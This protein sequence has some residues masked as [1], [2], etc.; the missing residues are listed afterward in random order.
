MCLSPPPGGTQPDTAAAV[1]V[2]GQRA[3]RHRAERDRLAAHSRRYSNGRLG[4]ALGAAGFGGWWL[5]GTPA[6]GALGLASI[7]ALAI[8]VLRHDRV[9][10]AVA[11]AD[12]LARINDEAA[13][14]ATRQWTALPPPVPIEVSPSHPYA[15]DLDLFGH[16][17]V[18]EWLG[19]PGTPRGRHT[20]ADYLLQPAAVDR[21]EPRQDVVRE[22]SPMLDFRQEL[23]GHGRLAGAIDGRE[24]SF[25][26][27]WAVTPSWLLAKP[28]LVWLSRL[29][30][31]LTLSLLAAHLAGGVGA[32]Y[33]LLPALGS[34]AAGWSVQRWLGPAI[35]RAGSWE[36]AIRGY[37]GLLALVAA[38]PLTSAHG[39]ALQARLGREQAA[40]HRALDRLQRLVA[41]GDLRLQPLLHLPIEALTMW[42]WHVWYGLDRWRRAH[43]AHVSDWLAVAGEV[44]ALAALAGA[45]YDHPDWTMPLVDPEARLLEARGLGHPLIAD[46]ARVANDV[47][48]GPPGTILF[49]TGSNMSGKSTL[50]RALGVNVV[51]AQAGGPVCASWLQL[52]ALAPH[53]SFRVSDS[54]EAGVSYFMASLTRLKSIVEAARHSSADGA[55]R[56]RVLYLLDE[57]LQGTN[58]AEREIAV[59]I[60]MDHLLA[61][62]AIGAITTHDLALTDS[63]EARRGARH[64]HFAEQVI[65]RDGRSTMHFDYRLRE[66][67]ATS[68][69]ALRLMEMVGLAPREASAGV[70][71]S[72][73]REH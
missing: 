36:P 41:L 63:P 50:L 64:V 31:L 49:V 45:S 18:F 68:R 54:L 55:S 70:S 2:Y 28:W 51:L 6:A 47:A 33:W 14:R 4:L 1:A 21:I 23:Q 59:R 46:G 44:E 3:A 58:S 39:R 22:L 29:L 66:G 9:E 61:S 26:L 30:P 15:E 19:P 65:Q 69:N 73:S 38:S 8:V 20:L 7:V 16:A 37:A 32:P 57:I 10:R 11:W 48:V 43:G 71:E 52:P 42:D 5:A 62:G 34:L 72:G 67:V 35:H 25:F 27:D 13:A 60:V 56:V 53:T 24:V 17:S 40:P 12:L